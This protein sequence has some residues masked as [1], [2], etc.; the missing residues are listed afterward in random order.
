MKNP[1]N[2][3]NTTKK[4]SSKSQEK[5]FSLTEEA[6]ITDVTQFIKL[7]DDTKNLIETIK[8]L[9]NES[10]SKQLVIELTNY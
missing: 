1:S 7:N 8:L 2:Q 6:K 10:M 9:E 5:N 3:R 4:Q